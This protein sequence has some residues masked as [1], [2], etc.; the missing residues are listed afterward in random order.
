MKKI[1]LIYL[2]RRGAGP[3]YALEMARALSKRFQLL[4]FIS[5]SVD[6]YQLWKAEEE[7]NLNFSLEFISTYNSLAGFLLK[8]LLFIRYIKIVDKI[9]AFGP[10][11]VYSP[12]GHF[13]EKFII[14]FLKCKCRVQTIHDVV[15][16]QGE[17]SL[18]FKL[19]R[20][21]F[22]YR[23]EKYVVLSS[24]FKPQ[25]IDRGVNEKDIIVVPHAVFNIYNTGTTILNDKN[26]YNRFLFFG[27]II[28]YK[29]LDVLLRSLEYILKKNPTVKL[30]IAGDGDINDYKDSIERYKDNI[31]LYNDWI[32]D[33]QVQFFF[34]NIDFVVLP[35]IHASQ[36][37]VI[38]LAYGFGKPVIATRIGGLPEQIVENETGILVNP[39]NEIELGN[40]IL[41]L[42]ENESQ[43]QYMKRKSE[44]YIANLSWEVSVNKLI[45]GLNE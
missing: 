36:S 40:A 41:N 12:M 8:S 4:C 13:W 1:V 10:D 5:E 11:I 31:E 27:R 16:H 2:G 37:G 45:D 42:L 34:T 43:L 23:S 22:S 24:V 28:K 15:L 30:V 25:L 29:G 20:R 17:N 35:Y 19:L 44:E 3:M 21:L 9:N 33:N 38:P 14:P 6:N 32:G 18:K 39:G 7:D 26:K